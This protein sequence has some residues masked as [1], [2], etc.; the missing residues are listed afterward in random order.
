MTTVV[1]KVVAS[2]VKKGLGELITLEVLA[3]VAVLPLV[4]SNCGIPPMPLLL[5]VA[6][7]RLID[8]VGPELPLMSYHEVPVPEYELLSFMSY[9]AFKARQWKK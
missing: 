3:P 6:W 4:I 8:R 7:L 2:Y 5:Y 1:F 9:R